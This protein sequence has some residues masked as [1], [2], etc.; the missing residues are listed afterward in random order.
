MNWNEYPQKES[1]TNKTTV[2]EH[3]YVDVNFGRERTARKSGLYQY[4]YGQILRVFDL[5]LPE[6][7]TV[8]FSLT[9]TRG[10]TD[11]ERIAKKQP[12]FCKY[13]IL[14]DICIYLCSL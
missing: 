1:G 6:Y 3:K 4:D 5:E 11:T 13:R 7:V 8:D 14:Y 10:S 2:N 9:D 12:R